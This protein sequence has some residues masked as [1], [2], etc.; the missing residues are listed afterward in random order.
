VRPLVL[1][2][3]VALPSCSKTSTPAAVDAAGSASATGDVA[4]PT[5]DV[6][7]H[8][9]TLPAEDAG[10]PVATGGEV[11][12]N[13]LRA[14]NRARLAGDR[15][16][17]TVL[18]GQGA[19]AAFDLGQRLCEAVVPHKPAD[20]PYLLKPNMGGFD[21][22]KD[23]DKT[24]GD[25]GVRGRTTDPE[26][27]RGV[28][29]CLKARGHQHV[30]IAEG[31]GATHKDWEKL[32]QV[33][34]Y[35]KMAREEKVPLVAMDDD[36]VFDVQ[37]DQ[38]GK[39]LGARGMDKTGM[40]T[41]LV[42]KILA[43]T[44]ARGVFISLPKIKAH[45]YAVFSLSVKGMQGTVMTSDKAPAFHNKW[46]T[47]RELVPWMKKQSQGK[48]DRAEY[49]ASLETFAGRIADVLEV[50]APDVVLA[51]GAPMMG[52][53]GFE[54][55][56]PS[57]EKVAVGGTNPILVD[58]VAAQLLG[59]WDRE[60]LAKE[61]GGH[62]TSP[63]LEVAAKRFG[64][65]LASPALTGDGA[66]LLSGPRPV[67]FVAMAS[68]SLHSDA[69]PALSPAAIAT[70]GS[71]ATPAVAPSASAPGPR[72]TVHAA[73]LGDATI[74]LDGFDNDAAWSRATAVTWDTDTAGEPTGIVTR[75]RFLHGPDAL[76]GFWQLERAGLNTDRTR[77]TD[78]PRPKLYEENCVE[79]FFTPDPARPKRY[80]ETE[81][82]PFGHYF[83]VSVDR[84]TGKSST[85]WT[86]DAHVSA[87]YDA[88]AQRA[89][90]EAKLAAPEIVS[91][92]TSGARLAFAL[93]RMEGK[94]P[95]RRYLAWSPPR[96]PHP[97]FHVPEAFGTLV[98]DP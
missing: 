4:P 61:L 97:D 80:L 53:D 38:P 82:G 15:S 84:E 91:A 65:D 3:L 28:V 96:T 59:L 98:V 20:T 54:K 48:E 79:M 29:R 74:H 93:Y 71:P 10:A 47:H 86:S 76:Y 11:D 2:C 64:V 81:L 6:S 33:T 41:L 25:D 42:P 56:W 12:A 21:W 94:S 34:G 70:L 90:I 13:A 26:F 32:V 77:P 73:A 16:P 39:P 75:A 31:W 46:R 17:V 62:R 83:D 85:A 14:K 63:L 36:G 45:R 72:P 8:A 50:E 40:P 78:V 49:V 60:E 1:A 9:S 19:H 35:G 68:F 89:T 27:V 7:T 87:N 67:H 69:T 30:T 37:G 24:G 44:L 43:D 51:E 95:D 5:P 92:L 66:A 57:R 55:L 18:Q 23:P 88:A 58:R 22:F 52:G